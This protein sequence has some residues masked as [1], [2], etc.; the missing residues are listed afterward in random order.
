MKIS[1][2]KSFSQDNVPSKQ[3][4]LDQHESDLRKQITDLQQKKQSISNDKTKTSEE[5]EK[6]K[7]AV[8]EKI[9]TLSSE[10]R[11]YQ[12]QK[13]QEEVSQKQEALKE[14]VRD[15]E[16]KNKDREQASEAT[17]FGNGESGVLISLSATKEQISNMKRIRAD[18]ERR[19]RVAVTDEEKGSLQKKINNAAK[20]IGKKIT[21]TENSIANSRDP[22]KKSNHIKQGNDQ[23]FNWKGQAEIA[24]TADDREESYRGNLAENRKRFF[25]TVSIFITPAL[26]L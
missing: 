23:A 4:S 21:I 16:G 12:I 14:A 11:Q 20:N 24:S 25:S 17:V 19:Q 18:L 3:P 15:A 2:S 9:Q 13:R 1:G 6:E 26:R 10:L 5:K 7:Q 22:K 8:Q